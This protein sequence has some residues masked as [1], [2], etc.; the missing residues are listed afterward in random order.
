MDPVTMVFYAAVCGLLAAVSP[1]FG[2]RIHRAAYGI[3]IGA[4]A[5]FVLP[6]I[7]AALGI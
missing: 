6:T 2:A 5:A 3:V 4:I 1:S 7:R